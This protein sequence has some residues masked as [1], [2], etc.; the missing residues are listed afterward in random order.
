MT[1]QIE[2]GAK[3]GIGRTTADGIAKKIAEIFEETNADQVSELAVNVGDEEQIMAAMKRLG[4]DVYSEQRFADVKRTK[5]A[6]YVLT[7]RRAR[8]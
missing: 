5:I 8:P 6:R 4:F 2:L 1:Q 7:V 3:M